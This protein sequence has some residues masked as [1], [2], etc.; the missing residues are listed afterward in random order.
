MEGADDAIGKVGCC[1]VTSGLG[2][3]GTRSLSSESEFFEKN[4]IRNKLWI[5]LRKGNTS[6]R[7]QGHTLRNS[8]SSLSTQFSRLSTELHGNLQ[9]TASCSVIYNVLTFLVALISTDSNESLGDGDTEK[10]IPLMLQ[11][12]CSRDYMTRNLSINFLAYGHHCL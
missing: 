12:M 4:G 9:L 1:V 7:Y 6:Q 11:C 5:G 3:N 10:T 2:L 8:L